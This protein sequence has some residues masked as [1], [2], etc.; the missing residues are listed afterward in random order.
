MPLTPNAVFELVYLVKRK[1]LQSRNFRRIGK[2]IVPFSLQCKLQNDVFASANRPKVGGKAHFQSRW[3]RQKI[4]VRLPTA[5]INSIF[6]IAIEITMLKCVFTA[7]LV[8]C[9]ALVR[10]TNQVRTALR[11]RSCPI[12]CK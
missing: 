10:T 4:V 9:Q 12:L 6:F 2:C 7:S 11:N 8:W 5:E 3:S 1:S